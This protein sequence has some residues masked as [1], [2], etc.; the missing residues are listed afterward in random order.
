MKDFISKNWEKILRIIGYISIFAIIFVKSNTKKSLL[1]DYIKY[2]PEVKRGE[3]N[4]G[5]GGIF[6]SVSDNVSSTFRSANP[7][8]VKLV[9]VLGLAILVVVILNLLIESASKKDAKKK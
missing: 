5:L 3:I 2:G 1:S 7:E 8:F 6:S 9:F 4:T